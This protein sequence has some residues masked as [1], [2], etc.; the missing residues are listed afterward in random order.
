MQFGKLQ[1]IAALSNIA[2]SI[3]VELRSAIILGKYKIEN[4]DNKP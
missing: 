2:I 4:G 3:A 1:I